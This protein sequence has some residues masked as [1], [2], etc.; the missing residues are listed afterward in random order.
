MNLAFIK[1]EKYDEKEFTFYVICHAF[2]G[3]VLL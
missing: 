2:N 1:T 3:A